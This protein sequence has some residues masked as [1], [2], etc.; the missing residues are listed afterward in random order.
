MHRFALTVQRL[1]TKDSVEGS[2]ITTS[3]AKHKPIGQ[4]PLVL[5]RISRRRR[6][7]ILIEGLRIKPG[8]LRLHAWMNPAVE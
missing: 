4:I 3:I 1:V 6:E 2:V 7:C 8:M 5:Q